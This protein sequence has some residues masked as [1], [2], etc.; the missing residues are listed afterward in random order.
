MLPKSTFS[1]QKCLFSSKNNRKNFYFGSI[2]GL[3]WLAYKFRVFS[4]VLGLGGLGSGRVRVQKVVGFGFEQK[5]RNPIGSGSGPIPGPDV[6]HCPTPLSRPTPLHAAT[7]RCSTLTRTSKKSRIQINYR[8]SP[9][10]IFGGRWHGECF[11]F[12]EGSCNY[13]SIVETT[14][15]R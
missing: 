7:R 2:S 14:V 5:T 1:V 13:G 11:L 3:I 4:R 10:I 15:G 6:N 12:F 9:I 8:D